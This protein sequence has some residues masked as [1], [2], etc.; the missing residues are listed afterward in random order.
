V[1]LSVV[2]TATILLSG[3]LVAST[4]VFTVVEYRDKIIIDAQREQIDY[5]TFSERSR[6]SITDATL[7]SIVF[8][9]E[10]G[11]WR[12][13]LTIYIKNIGGTTFDLNK[14]NILV[15]GSI[16]SN[17]IDK[18]NITVNGRSALFLPPNSSAVVPVQNCY[19][20]ESISISTRVAAVMENGIA[21][22]CTIADKTPIADAGS[23]YRY[24]E[25]NET[26]R[27]DASRSLD[28][29]LLFRE[30]YDIL[31]NVSIDNIG[32]IGEGLIN[33]YWDFDGNND[34]DGDG[35]LTND[36][37]AEGKV[38]D[39]VFHARDLNND[40]TSD[41]YIVTLTV[42]DAKE[43]TDTKTITVY[44]L[45][46][47]QPKIT[48]NFL[49]TSKKN[50]TSND[51]LL[52]DTLTFNATDSVT[53]NVGYV[54]T[55][56]RGWQ[57]GIGLYFAW[58]F[59]GDGV[60]DTNFTRYPTVQY[61]YTKPQCPYNVT[62]FVKDAD[63]NI[64]SYTQYLNITKLTPEF[65]YG[66]NPV[67]VEGDT[68]TFDAT[69]SRNTFCGAVE[70]YTD[71][72]GNGMRDDNEQYVDVNKNNIYDGLTYTWNFGDGTT[73]T[74]KTATH[75]Y[76][77][78]LA[79]GGGTVNAAGNFAVTLTITDINGNSGTVVH[80]VTI[81][82]KMPPVI[83]QQSNITI[84]RSAYTFSTD[85]DDN[86]NQDIVCYWSFGNATVYQTIVTSTD[87]NPSITYT[88]N[89]P[90]EYVVMKTAIDATGNRANSRFTVTVTL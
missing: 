43:R 88:F 11:K 27:F 42:K 78:S 54:Q 38:A 39:Y 64:L 7:D 80:N 30:W 17:Y 25:D 73:G 32:Q 46:R 83:S 4:I 1:G 76:T 77:K 18:S 48:K 60:V 16:I 31:Y 55:A 75:K 3:L 67:L 86:S 33:Y 6:I 52:G 5:T 82:D 66:S 53:D 68:I 23:K 36:R 72:N 37:D 21:A 26:V 41:P 50:V 8:I 62:L 81:V 9:N 44:V 14:L 12:G 58:D 70:P 87:T 61:I 74:G 65:T 24:V 79:F 10:L 20:D 2:G 34:S 47:T 49:V 15:N 13:N 85:T 29:E 69:P 40:G 35:N 63:N 28:S 57:I 90:G 56:D 19:F 51:Q 45:D 71:T 84:P 89:T 22:Y 59:N